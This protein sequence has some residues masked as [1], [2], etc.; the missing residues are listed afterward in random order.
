MQ[1][2]LTQESLVS[3]V[4]VCVASPS[5]GPT[6]SRRAAAQADVPSEAVPPDSREDA[7]SADTWE[8]SR[9]SWRANTHSGCFHVDDVVM[10]EVNKIRRQ[11]M[12]SHTKTPS[13]VCKLLIWASIY[14]YLPCG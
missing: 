7:I 2:D 3:R 13:R 11:D 1:R 4:R 10:L 5:P 12:I 8:I 14:H 6:S 9:F